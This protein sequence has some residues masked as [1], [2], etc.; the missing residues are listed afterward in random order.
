MPT[1]TGRVKFVTA[2]AIAALT[3][4]SSTRSQAKKLNVITATT[5]MA[6]LAQEVGGDHISVESL[7]KGYQDPHSSS[8]SQAFCS[9]C[10]R[11][12]C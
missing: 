7:A 6:A 2:I 3:L 12:M 4:F 1:A 11:R 10:V 9:S 8:P 5:D